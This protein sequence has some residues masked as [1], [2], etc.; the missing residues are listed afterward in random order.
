MREEKTIS[1]H[2]ALCTN[3]KQ[4]PSE[5]FCL[6][7]GITQKQS[8]R[9]EP[10]SP[11]TICTEPCSKQPLGNNFLRGKMV[12]SAE[13]KGAAVTEEAELSQSAGFAHFCSWS[14]SRLVLPLAS[15]ALVVALRTES[16]KNGRVTRWWLICNAQQQSEEDFNRHLLPC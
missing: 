16:C 12:W 14:Q 1:Y 4:I 13:N 10:V 2:N 5:C 3:S 8:A 6:R 7:W 15:H 9:Q 11:V